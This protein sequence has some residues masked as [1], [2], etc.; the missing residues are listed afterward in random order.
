[1]PAGKLQQLALTSTTCWQKSKRQVLKILPLAESQI[2]L[3]TKE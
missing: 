2:Q 3:H 1:M